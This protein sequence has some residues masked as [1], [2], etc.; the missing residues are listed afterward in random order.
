VLGC[1]FAS[2]RS[3][4]ILITKEAQLRAGFLGQT[5]T[6]PPA[7]RAGRGRFINSGRESSRALTLSLRLPARFRGQIPS[8]RGPLFRPP[9]RLPLLGQEGKSNFLSP[10]FQGELYT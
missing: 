9:T 1:L 7:A 4:A 6:T 8:K 3:N 5:P 10:P 2:I